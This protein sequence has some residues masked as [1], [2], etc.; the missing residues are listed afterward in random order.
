MVYGGGEKVR[1]SIGD[2]VLVKS[3][4]LTSKLE[5]KWEGSF[6]VSNTPDSVL[7]RLHH[8]MEVDM[9]FIQLSV[10]PILTELGVVQVP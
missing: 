1:I 9:G 3:P 5:A 4:G 10:N 8:D 7:Y 6:L 2:L